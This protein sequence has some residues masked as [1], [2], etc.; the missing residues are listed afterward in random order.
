MLE[1][2][3]VGEFLDEDIRWREKVYN[4]IYIALFSNEI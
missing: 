2:L 3:R 1:F 4:Y